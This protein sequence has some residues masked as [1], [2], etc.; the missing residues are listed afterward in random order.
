MLF[1]EI[2]KIRQKVIAETLKKFEIFI[3]LMELKKVEMPTQKEIEL[4]LSKIETTKDLKYIDFNKQIDIEGLRSEIMEMVKDINFKKEFEFKDNETA[5]NINQYLP[6]SDRVYLFAEISF[7]LEFW[8]DQYNNLQPQKI[9]KDGLILNKDGKKFSIKQIA[10]IHYYNG[11]AINED[12]CD[13]V[14]NEYGHNSGQKLKLVYN[15]FNKNLTRTKELTHT[16]LQNRIKD[17][18]SI[19]EYIT[20]DKQSKANDQL[21]KL[22]IDLEDKRDY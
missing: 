1:M 18:V 8:K 5:N 9:D 12:N 14:I 13:K 11:I 17:I 19:L 3:P 22:K 21:N 15:E 2:N 7:M 16:E 10:L 4:F 6:I 20:N